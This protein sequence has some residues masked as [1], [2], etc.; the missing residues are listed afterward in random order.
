[1]MKSLFRHFLIG[2][3]AAVIFVGLLLWTNTAG[4]MTLIANSSV[5]GLALTLLLVGLISTFGPIA[6]LFAFIEDNQEKSSRRRGN[7]SPR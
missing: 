1:M 6:V 4:I 3:L 5:G 7:R 2:A